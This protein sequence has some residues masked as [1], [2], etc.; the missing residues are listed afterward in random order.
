MP[1][2]IYIYM[3]VYMKIY[4]Y[5]NIVKECQRYKIVEFELYPL[6]N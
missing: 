2:N 1:K 6:V 5:M 4:V 3:C